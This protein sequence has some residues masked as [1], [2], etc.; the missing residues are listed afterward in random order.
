MYVYGLTLNIYIQEWF[1]GLHFAAENHK[2]EKKSWFEVIF[3]GYFIYG[4]LFQ[5]DLLR[6]KESYSNSM[7]V[8]GN[9]FH[10]KKSYLS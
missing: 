1:Y 5:S 4:L 9:G 7:R 6:P 8:S 3:A 10:D 2:T